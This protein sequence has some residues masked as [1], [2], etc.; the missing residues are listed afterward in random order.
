MTWGKVRQ[1]LSE[2]QGLH[3][4][5]VKVA[6]APEAH[7]TPGMMPEAIRIT[8]FVADRTDGASEAMRRLLEVEN[9]EVVIEEV[10]LL[11]PVH[12]SF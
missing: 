11:L 2:M 9:V 4:I 10:P 7:G 1:I 8:D 5:R 6:K 3:E 12:S